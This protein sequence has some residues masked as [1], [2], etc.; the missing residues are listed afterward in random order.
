[1]RLDQLLQGVALTRRDLGDRE[2]AGVSYDTRTLRPG[3]LFAALPGYKTD[4]QRFLQ[5][6]LDKGAAAVLCRQAPDFPGPW[7]VAPDPREALAA[8]AAKM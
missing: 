1:M 2:I 3:E 8:V 7:L 5:E 6:A 4:G